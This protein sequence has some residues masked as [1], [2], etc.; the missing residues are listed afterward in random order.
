[1]RINYGAIISQTF[2]FYRPSTTIQPPTSL[3]FKHLLSSIYRR[4]SGLL[5]GGELEALKTPPLLPQRPEKKIVRFFPN[6]SSQPYL[7]VPPR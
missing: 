3:L 7:Y 4:L 2:R 1:M 5:C 6:L